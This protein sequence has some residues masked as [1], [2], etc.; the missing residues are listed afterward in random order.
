MGMTRQADDQGTQWGE[1][2]RTCCRR[3]ALARTQAG[4]TPNEK[5]ESN[6]TGP[7]TLNPLRLTSEPSTH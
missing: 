3:H 7:N 1:T 6:T 4:D 2:R 5:Y